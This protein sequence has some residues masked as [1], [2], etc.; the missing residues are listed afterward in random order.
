MVEIALKSLNK[1]YKVVYSKPE[2]DG[3]YRKDVSSEKLK[4][5]LPGFEF[6]SLH[7]GIKM[8]Y[9]KIS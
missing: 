5:I 8:V 6:T 1:N 7:K 9:N 2:L 4:L 3:Q